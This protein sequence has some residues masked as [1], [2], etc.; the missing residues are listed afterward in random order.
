MTPLG[1]FIDFLTVLER[2]GGQKN[3]CLLEPPAPLKLENGPAKAAANPKNLIVSASGIKN[4]FPYW[5]LSIFLF[6]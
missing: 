1:R 5:T 6:D 4:F 2:I 3:V